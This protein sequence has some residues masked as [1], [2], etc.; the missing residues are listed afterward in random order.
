V[1]SPTI[2]YPTPAADLRTGRGESALPRPDLGAK[3]QSLP[4]AAIPHHIAA[5]PRLSPTDL[6]VLA[7]LLYHARANASCWASDRCLAQRCATAPDRGPASVG[8]IQRSLKRLEACGHI[9]R[10]ATPETLTGRR[11]WLAWRAVPLRA[12]EQTP[13]RAGEQQRN[14]IVGEKKEKTK[15]PERSRP[16][17]PRVPM[18][19]VAQSNPARSV[20]PVPAMAQSNPVDG[21]P[22]PPTGAGAVVPAPVAAPEPRTAAL[23]DPVERGPLSPHEAVLGGPTPPPEPPAPEGATL[24]A[25][26]RSPAK[27][28][29]QSAPG[30]PPVAAQDAQG[31]LADSLPPK[32][33]P[34]PATSPT[35]A[36][37][38]LPLTA[39]QQA[40]LDALPAATR[41]LVLTWLL[42]GDRILV[43]EAKKKLAP[44]RPR[45]EAPRTL[46]EVLG[47]I[48][49]DPSFPALAADW[50]AS[51]LD[52][53]KSWSGFK[54]RCEEAWRGDL[55]VAR[56]LSAFEQATSP[57]ARNRGALFMF[58]LRGGARDG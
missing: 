33:A 43:A 42:T 27:R 44:P 18:P 20:P 28:S 3:T 31:A 36:G 23:E 51:A 47:R 11:I 53:R 49:E 34:A 56:L 15:S 37:P 48:R 58:A 50:L 40:R 6:R 41:D 55:P 26:P 2:R 25:G 22:L 32:A 10:E 1:N 17:P 5:D 52:D 57:K 19:A 39:E 24:P 29:D 46:P 38:A 21:P 13:M 54:A 45:P 35:T 9:A 14:V 16:E 30:S 8:T 7:A 4:F 12:G